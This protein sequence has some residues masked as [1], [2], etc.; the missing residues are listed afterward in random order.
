MYH[1]PDYAIRFKWLISNRCF[2]LYVV[3]RVVHEIR[4]Y[5][6]AQLVCTRLVTPYTC[7]SCN[8]LISDEAK[9]INQ[10]FRYEIRFAHTCTRVGSDVTEQQL[11]V[12]TWVFHHLASTTGPFLHKDKKLEKNTALL[13]SSA[14]GFVVWTYMEREKSA[15]VCSRCSEEVL[16]YKQETV[17]T[18][19]V[20]ASGEV[21]VHPTSNPQ[22]QNN[23]QN[24]N[25]GHNFQTVKSWIAVFYHRVVVVVVV[26]FNLFNPPL[27]LQFYSIAPKSSIFLQIPCGYLN[28]LGSHSILIFLSV[29]QW[30][31]QTRRTKDNIAPVMYVMYEVRFLWIF[32]QKNHHQCARKHLNQL[33]CRIFH[34][35]APNRLDW[36]KPHQCKFE[37]KVL[38]AG[39]DLSTT[40]WI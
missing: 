25:S 21:E 8:P 2:W 23:I 15:V 6:H 28:Y 18:V 19:D 14:S 7:M 31:V 10:D 38:C 12:H 13:H 11:C 32:R 39:S 9:G 35:N 37:N 17:R 24:V 36:N 29:L 3:D 22:S 34:Q 27:L 16:A 5:V 33:Q 40:V 4:L 1:N 20:T 26:V 30:D